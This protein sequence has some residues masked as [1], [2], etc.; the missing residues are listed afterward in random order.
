VKDASWFEAAV[1]LGH[2][3]KIWWAHIAPWEPD[4]QGTVVSVWPDK[5]GLKVQED[6][7][8]GNPTYVSFEQITRVEGVDDA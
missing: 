2:K 8:N 5:S 7:V 6:G 1:R 4:R 3:P